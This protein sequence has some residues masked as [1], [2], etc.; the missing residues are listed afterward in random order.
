MVTIAVNGAAGRM[1]SRILALA[2]QAPKKYKVGGSFD[3]AK[4]GLS[5][6]SPEGLKKVDVL[7]DFSSPEGT[8]QSLR[9]C[10]SSKTKLVIGTTG[11]GP[12][13]QEDVKK[14]SKVIPIIYS[15]NMS[16]GIN[17]VAEALELLASRLGREFKISITEAH[18]IHKKDAPRGTA[19]LLKNAMAVAGKA[20]EIK[21][22]REGEIVGDHTVLFS[23][24]AE[25]IEITHRAQS[26]DVFALGALRAAV[27]LA[28]SGKPGKLY[29][30]RDVLRG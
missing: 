26:R 17:L 25:T 12:Q 23:G 18:H 22:I 9:A 16:V 13:T 21:S 1:G 20:I 3:H 19:L 29:S 4:R 15:A 30:M 10:V 6:L 7:I 14:A 24:P 27:F 28:K 11:L 8:D 5:P 2:A